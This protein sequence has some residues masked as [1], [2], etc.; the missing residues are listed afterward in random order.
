MGTLCVILRI[1]HLITFCV[2][3]FEVVQIFSIINNFLMN[4][5]AYKFF[6]LFLRRDFQKG[7]GSKSRVFLRLIYNILPNAFQNIYVNLN[8]HQLT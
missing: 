5:F 2:L 8:S 4:I 1:Y 6:V 3:E 7:N